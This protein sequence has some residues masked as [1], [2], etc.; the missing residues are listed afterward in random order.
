MGNTTLADWNK[1]GLV[2]KDGQLVQGKKLVSKKVEKLPDLLE[3]GKNKKI[4][5]AKKVTDEAGV[6]FD[7]G[8][9]RYLYDLLQ[10]AGIDF[11][12]QVKYVLQNKFRY[13]GEAIRAITLT[14]DFFL[15]GKNMIIDT[16]G[17]AND[18]A[19]L[20][21]KMLKWVLH[22]NWLEF[23]LPTPIIELPST[24]KECDILLNRLLF[25]K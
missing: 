1:Q 6:H 9:E 20:K 2:F 23:G 17:Y 18:V 15:A 16:K 10:G 19:P 12:F 7:S 11:D 25:D 14:V 24:K 5:N 13:H 3:Q 21:Y 22:N 4:M 8:L